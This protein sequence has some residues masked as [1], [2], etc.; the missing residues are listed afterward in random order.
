MIWNVNAR[1][2][3][4]VTRS[5]TK[6]IVVSAATISTTNITGF[7]AISCGSSWTKADEIAG[8]R[9]FGSSIVEAVTF[10]CSFMASMDVTPKRDRSE[11][12]I[13]VHCEVLDDR[14]K[15]QRREEG[16][17]ADDQD[18]A[19]DESDE[20]P[21]GGWKRT[22]RGGMRLLGRER[23]CNRHGRNDHEE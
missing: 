13:G 23:A 14:P 8:T 21:A 11:Q 6:I 1:F 2:P 20:Q 16:E 15:R 18:Y 3:P 9:I 17:T 12:G 7:L 4:P 5:R 10:F 19:D 22:H